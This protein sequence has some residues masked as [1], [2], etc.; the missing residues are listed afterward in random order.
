MEKRNVVLK[1]GVAWQSRDVYKKLNQK[2]IN[3]ATYALYFSLN[4]S[5]LELQVAPI[6]AQ[7]IELIKRY[8]E[9]DDKGITTVSEDGLDQFSKEFT[10]LMEA[11]LTFN[12]YMLDPEKLDI[13]FDEITGEEVYSIKYMVNYE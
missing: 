7:R 2:Q 9:E 1:A 12:L 6:E 11:D 13:M 3:S 5:E 8:G 10:E 4:A